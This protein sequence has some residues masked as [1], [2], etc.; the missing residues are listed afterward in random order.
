MLTIL[1][2][3][4]LAL[5]YSGVVS[6][7]FRS[8]ALLGYPGLSNDYLDC[9]TVSFKNAG[10]IGDLLSAGDSATILNISGMLIV[11]FVSAAVGGGLYYIVAFLL[12]KKFGLAALR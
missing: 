8:I 3:L 1:V 2:L 11:F 4:F 9:S 7:R 6:Q 5:P 12:Q 10:I